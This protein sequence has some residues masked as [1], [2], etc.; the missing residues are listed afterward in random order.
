MKDTPENKKD[1]YADIETL[2]KYN[3]VSQ[4]YNRVTPPINSYSQI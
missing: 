2:E 3:P 1:I 4:Y